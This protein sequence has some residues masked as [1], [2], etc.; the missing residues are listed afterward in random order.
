ME[1]ISLI[2]NAFPNSSNSVSLVKNE[3]VNNVNK[4]TDEYGSGVYTELQVKEICMKYRLRFLP[5]TYYKGTVPIEAI[6]KLKEFI[7]SNDKLKYLDGANAYGFERN[8]FILAPTNMFNISSNTQK[9][10]DENAKMRELKRLQEQDPA[11]FI[12]LE[13]NRYLFIKEW[14]N[15]FSFSRKILGALTAKLSTLNTFFF[16]SWLI[17]IIAGIYGFMQ[18]WNNLPSS[19]NDK[20]N[21][22][23][24]YLIIYPVYAIIYLY[25]GISWTSSGS[26]DGGKVFENLKDWDKPYWKIKNLYATEHNWNSK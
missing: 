14:G 11:L 15:S 18:I 4:L 25:I 12:K 2:M 5:S 19:I 7:K 16:I 20:G 21:I 10:K 3:E 1:D 24:G 23:N 17:F 6:H 26:S 9:A 13:D 22:I 8:V